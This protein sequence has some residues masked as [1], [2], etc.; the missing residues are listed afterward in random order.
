M[1]CRL[2][3]W[4]PLVASGAIRLQTLDWLRRSGLFQASQTPQKAAPRRP[5]GASAEPA[6]RNTSIDDAQALVQYRA[7]LV[8]GPSIS[9][10]DGVA[11][12][13]PIDTYLAQARGWPG[14]GAGERWGMRVAQSLP[15]AVINEAGGLAAAKAIGRDPNWSQRRRLYQVRDSTNARWTQLERRL[16]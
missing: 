5:T 2:L 6:W 3:W 11:R 10:W 12:Q 8:N 9:A 16:G 13:S 1:H 14:R 15:D 4:G 7:R